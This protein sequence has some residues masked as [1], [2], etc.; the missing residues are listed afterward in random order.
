MGK[1]LLADQRSMHY[2]VNQLVNA[3]RQAVLSGHDEFCDL[4]MDSLTASQ[5]EHIRSL[6]LKLK[7]SSETT[8]K[9]W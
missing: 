3:Y 5:K 2:T 6:V 9:L 4:L 7:G 1:I 8:K